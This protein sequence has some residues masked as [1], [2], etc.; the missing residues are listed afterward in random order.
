MIADEEREKDQ[1]EVLVVDDSPASLQLLTGILTEH[2][3]RVRPAS[4]GSLALRSVAARLPDLILL[5]VRMP[6]M[7]GFEVCR[8]LKSDERS[9]G[10][11]VLFISA[12]GET[13]DKIKGFEAGGVDYITKPFEPEEVLVRVRTHLRLSELTQRLHEAKESLE[14]RVEERTAELARANRELQ[15]EIAKLRKAEETIEYQAYHD[16]LTGLPNRAQLM[17]RFEHELVQSQRNQKK[18]AVLHLDLDRFKVINDSLGHA[19]G[20]KVIRAVAERLRSLTRKSDTLARMGSDEFIILLADINRAE[21]AAL[22]ARKII[23]AM[24]RSFP[25]DGHELYVTASVGISMYPEDS[26]KAEILLGNADIAVSHVKERG[27]NDYQFF[28]PAINVRTVERLLLESSLRQSVERGELVLYYQPEVN[29]KTG[30]VMCLEALVRWRHPNLGLLLPAQFIP[31]AEEIGFVTAVDEWVIRNACAQNKAWHDTGFPPLCVTVNLSAQ[32]F[33]QP[34]LATMVSRIVRETGLAPGY[35]DIEVTESAAMR[36]IELA[37][38][39]LSGLHDM[40][41][42][43]SIDD[44]G[45]GYSSLNYLKRF[46]VH[47]LKI[48]QSFIRGVSTDPDDQAI[49]RAVIAM[50]H[51]LKM[52][53]VAEGVET[54]EQLS[55][56]RDNDCDEMQG[57]LFSKPLP[58]QDVEREILAKK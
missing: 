43:L 54:D 39:N 53:V 9:R 40:G 30:D 17:L 25:A 50:G 29:I 41:V 14:K 19:V 55:F 24:Q 16:L 10:V 13:I 33:Q 20:D 46:P 42:K 32:Q 57:F 27:R 45:T 5:D 8:R 3:Y 11:P 23:D 31:V 21:D 36:N 47:T 37:I 15:A 22:F 38:P 28:N 51:H 2:G 1:R 52:K 58:P 26:E 4:G 35:L 18:L 56:L 7:D 6:D 44:F 49:V 48:D 12:S 34:A